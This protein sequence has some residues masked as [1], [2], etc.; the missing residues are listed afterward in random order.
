MRSRHKQACT[1]Q[2]TFLSKS[3][4]AFLVGLV[5]AQ[6]CFATQMLM[7]LFWPL[8]SGGNMRAASLLTEKSRLNAITGLLSDQ[9]GSVQQTD[10]HC[11][12]AFPKESFIIASPRSQSP[13]MFFA[14]QSHG[15]T[16]PK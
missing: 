12:K 7:Y 10:K 4:Y 16:Y 14:L 6:N 9:N 1:S 8:S 3:P 5:T 2:E 15:L 13:F 11:A